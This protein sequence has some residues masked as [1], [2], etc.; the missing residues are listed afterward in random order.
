[1]GGHADLLLTDIIMPDMNGVEFAHVMRARQPD[2]PVI[3]MSGYHDLAEVPSDGG[4]LAEHLLQKPVT[5]EALL[6]AVH[7]S[8]GMRVPGEALPA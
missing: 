7:E 5:P 3:L 1:M 8:L 4:T 6:H 2:L